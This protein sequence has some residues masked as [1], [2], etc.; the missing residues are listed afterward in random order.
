MREGEKRKRKERERGRGEKGERER[1][2]SGLQTS[3]RRWRCYLTSGISGRYLEQKRRAISIKTIH[4]SFSDF[5]RYRR[6]TALNCHVLALK[7]SELYV[8]MYMRARA[9]V[10]V[11]VYVQ[12]EISLRV[13][14]EN[15]AFCRL[16][17]EIIM[18]ALCQQA[19]SL[20]IILKLNYEKSSR[21]PWN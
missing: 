7:L 14:F 9:R 5:L 15:L 13:P 19:R 16:P 8:W 1:K 18:R 21:G 4:F 2:P 10:C 17:A 12:G 20:C 6:A 3:G 11:C